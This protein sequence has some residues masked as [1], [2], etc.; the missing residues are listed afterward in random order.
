MSRFNVPPAPPVSTV[1][2]HQGGAGFERTDPRDELFLLAVTNAVGVDTFYEAADVRDK[3]FVDLIRQVT[4]SDPTWVRSFAAWLRQTGNMRTAPVIL[5]AEYVA[6]GG[7]HGRSLVDSVLVRADEPAELLSYWRLKHGR[8]IPLPIKR[9]V[10]DAC[11]RLYTEKALLK[12]DGRDK[13]MRF[14]DVIEIVHPSPRDDRQ[15]ALFRHAIDRRHN[16]KDAVDETIVLPTLARDKALMAVPP[17]ARRAR[18][19][20]VLAARWSWERLAGWLPGGMDAEAWEAVIPSMGVAALIKNLRNFDQAGI[21]TG[22]V[23][24]V[25]AKLTSPVDIRESRQFPIRYLTAWKNTKSM[26]WGYPLEEA[27]RLSTDNVPALPG[28]SLILIDVSPSMV[29][30]LLSKQT[31]Y[32]RKPEGNPARPLRYEAA[33]VFGLALAQR[34]QAADVWLFDFAAEEFAF[35]KSGSVLRSVE[36]IGRRAEHGNGTDTLGAL[37]SAYRP[38]VHDRVVILTDEQT[39]VGAPQYHGHQ[40][41]A[42]Y[43]YVGDPDV[44]RQALDNV[45]IPVTTFNLA[46]YSIGHTPQWRNWYTIG[47]LTDACFA[48]LP[49]IERRTQNVWPW[50]A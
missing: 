39:G 11:V 9:G 4:S 50:Q 14:G 5:A 8:S 25:I 35:P 12:W 43:G 7:P 16:R 21:G 15:S 46:G 1:H 41:R 27:V 17:E 2:T 38:G 49:A 19:A 20:D 30:D 13:E 28:R 34:A 33:A 10:A 23:A 44:W 3:R 26:R 42:G 6:A 37:L 18:L 40:S 32:A 24:T 36:E 45:K 31:W 48:L 22:A 47:G 29:D